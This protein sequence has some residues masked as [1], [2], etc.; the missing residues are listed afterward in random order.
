MNKKSKIRILQKA[1]YY[2]STEYPQFVEYATRQQHSHWL[3]TDPGVDNDLHSM[4][5]DLSISERHAIITVLKLFVHYELRLGTN[6]WSA[7]GNTMP[8]SEVYRMGSVFAAMEI[9]VHSPF[10]AEVNRL[11]GKD[12]PEFY[13]EYKESAVLVDRIQFLEDHCRLGHRASVMDVLMTLATLSLIEGVVLYSSFALLKSFQANGSNSIP[14]IVT[15]VDYVVVDEQ[16]HAEGAAS[17]FQTLLNEA[18]LTDEEIDVLRS[19]IN[20]LGVGVKEHEF[21]IIQMIFSEGK[22]PSITQTQMNHFV[23]SRVDLVLQYL[24]NEKIYCVTYNPVGDWFY[25]NI[26]SP[27]L[28]DFFN[29]TATSYTRAW[30]ENGLAWNNNKGE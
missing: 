22:I 3:H 26:N 5:I 6:F 20:D 14:N 25:N 8:R 16:L 30:S 12:T 18:E 10:Y 13:S 21:E 9:A 2:S 11:L 17:L 7:I 1:D 28:V 27:T 29:R 24:G 19:K 23:E 15:G 4:L